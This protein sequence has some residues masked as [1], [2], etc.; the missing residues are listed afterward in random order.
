MFEWEKQTIKKF[1]NLNE[2]F[3]GFAAITTLENLFEIV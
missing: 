1:T 2:M 3:G